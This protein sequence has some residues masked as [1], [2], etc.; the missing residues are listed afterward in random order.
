MP[1]SKKRSIYHSHDI[2]RDWADRDPDRVA[3][4][5]DKHPDLPVREIATQLKLRRKACLKFPA[6]TDKD[7]LY[8]EKSLEQASS[9]IAAQHKRN[10]LK[11]R[12]MDLTGGL[13]SDLIHNSD[14]I[15]YMVYCDHDSTLCELFRHNCAVLGLKP[16]E[17]HTGD[18]I[19]ILR[20]YPDEYF[21]IIFV[22]PD[23][24]AGKGRSVSLKEA[25]PD[26]TSHV[27]LI[28]KKGKSLL[29]KASPA[30]D[31][32]EA[33]RQLPGLREYHVV[34]VDG[35]VKEVLLL[36]GMQKDE[37]V[38]CVASVI[39]KSNTVQIIGNG[40]QAKVWDGE[41]PQYFCEPDPAIIRAGLSSELAVDANVYHISPKSVYLVGE[42]RPM[43]FPGR[44]FKI[45]KV[46]SANFRSIKDWCKQNGY[47]HANIARRD[48]PNDP[49]SIRKALKLKD[50]GDLYLFF[51]KFK[52][53]YVCIACEKLNSDP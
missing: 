31:P 29:I 51:T 42:K 33:K 16:D 13:G 15:S 7:I 39:R 44:T 27:D 5:A 40:N 52:G 41:L 17:I 20:K 12:V 38:R 6:W 45:A 24:R 53:N 46:M 34:S 2:L 18:S 14:H 21:D 48:F 23:R 25:S 3:L 49:D 10:W 8:T 32:L 43:D 26:I 50:G 11:G 37:S 47:T 30:L 9:Q 4:D 36:V 35:E 19:E 28:L 22:D 1:M